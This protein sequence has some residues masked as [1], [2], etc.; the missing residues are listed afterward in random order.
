MPHD[1]A[2]DCLHPQ[3][4]ADSRDGD[5]SH[6]SCIRRGAMSLSRTV[7]A[8]PNARTIA[9]H[10]VLGELHAQLMLMR[11]AALISQEEFDGVVRGFQ[12]WLWRHLGLV[13][14]ASLT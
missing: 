2:G 3:A 6:Q 12:Q 7:R 1:I 8:V 14:L 10:P 5:K 9:Q 13:A 4:G 11:D